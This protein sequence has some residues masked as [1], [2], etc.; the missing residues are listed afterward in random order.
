MKMRKILLFTLCV[1]MVSAMA[2]MVYA[3]GKN[4]QSGKSNT[5]HLYFYEKTPID[6]NPELTP[7]PIVEDGAWGKM[8][9]NLSGET[10][11][12][13][14]NGHG[15]EPDVCYMLIYYPD[16]WPGTGLV[17]LGVGAAD[18]DGNVHI[19]SST[20]TGDLPIDSDDNAS[21]GAKIWLILC[22]DL[23]CDTGVWDA[24][25][26]TEY[27]F[28]ATW[29]GIG[30]DDINDPAPSKNSTNTTTWATIKS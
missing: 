25:N 28:E 17:C 30:F 19:Q 13:V 14:F 2:T 6:P 20:T 10:L 9:Y 27:L 3:A 24:W 1:L 21:V 15:L 8:K 11:D 7:W 12:I 5:G 18:L 23:D 22:D 29:T 16:P 26:P 4:G